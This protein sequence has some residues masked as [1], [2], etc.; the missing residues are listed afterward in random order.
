MVNLPY[1]IKVYGWAFDPFKDCV[2]GARILILREDNYLIAD[3]PIDNYSIDVA[4]H[5]NNRELTYARWEVHVKKKQLIENIDQKL[6]IYVFLP[7]RNTAVNLSN[8]DVTRDMINTNTYPRCNIDIVGGGCN[9]KCY[10]CPSGCNNNNKKSLTFMTYNRFTEL[11][12]YMLL[13]NIISN[14]TVV[15]LY[16]WSESYCNKDFVKIVSYLERE[17]LIYALSTNASTLR[18]FEDGQ[19]LKNLS[20]LTISMPGFSQQSY[21]RQH[22]FNF[23]II[24][25]NIKALV[26][27][28]RSCGFSGSVNISYHVYQHNIN[29]IE[30]AK[31]FAEALNANLNPYYALMIDYEMLQQYIDQ[32]LP[33]HVL[34]RASQELFLH[35]LLKGNGGGARQF[36]A[37]SAI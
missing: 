4:N 20:A 35:F 26:S 1:E 7:E 33:S 23:E 29:E 31:S 28:Y 10:W 30:T 9:A 17:G 3:I 21:N 24:L 5:F 18:L 34:Y 19:S 13:N 16:N 25:N 37:M 32:T 6:L 15:E 14:K 36:M 11:I 2:N 27:N 8:L 22:G 12:E